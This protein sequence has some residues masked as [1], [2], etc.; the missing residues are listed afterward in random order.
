[1]RKPGGLSGS[2]THAPGSGMEDSAEE[3]LFGNP[4][5]HPAEGANEEKDEG[6]QER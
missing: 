3:I 5:A 6:Q 1:M 2:A 4:P